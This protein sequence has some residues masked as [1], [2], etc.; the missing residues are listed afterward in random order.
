VIEYVASEEQVADVLT[1]PISSS[2]FEAF[3]TKLNVK[4]FTTLSL[5]GDVERLIELR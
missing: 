4:E 2:K 1:K 3:R 5:K